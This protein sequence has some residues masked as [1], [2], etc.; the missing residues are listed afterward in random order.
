MNTASYNIHIIG[1]N[2]NEGDGEGSVMYK[3][4]GLCKTVADFERFLDTLKKA[5]GGRGKFW[6]H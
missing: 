4:L 1:D 3:A 2:S 6:R 5:N